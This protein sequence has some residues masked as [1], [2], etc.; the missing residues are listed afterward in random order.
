MPFFTD[1]EAVNQGVAGAEAAFRGL[2]DK[3][4]PVVQQCAAGLAQGIDTIGQRERVWAAVRWTGG[5][6]S[7][8]RSGSPR[9]CGR[10]AAR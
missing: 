8:V 10:V 7:G 9:R 4:A 2:A 3:D 5:G 6:P 1:L